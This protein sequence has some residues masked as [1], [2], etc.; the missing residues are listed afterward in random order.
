MCNTKL[1]NKIY[2]QIFQANSVYYLFGVFLITISLSKPVKLYVYYIKFFLQILLTVS[3]VIPKFFAEIIGRKENL[4]SKA[5]QIVTSF[6]AGF[7]FLRTQLSS[8]DDGIEEV[9]KMIAQSDMDFHRL[10]VP[11]K[12]RYYKRVYY[13]NL[14]FGIKNVIM[15]LADV[16]CLDELVTMNDHWII[17]ALIVNVYTKY[18]MSNI[19]VLK[20]YQIRDRF[21][22][23]KH[24][25]TALSH[26]S[27]YCGKYF[28]ILI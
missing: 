13:R 11:F 4:I 5:L 26:K 21:S 23:I 9:L 7:A 16:F 22:R 27:I 1:F 8:Y 24:V 10:K 17:L 20:L 15:T 25:I 3:L 19:I 12:E 14:F 6:F 2:Y 18:Y 28:S